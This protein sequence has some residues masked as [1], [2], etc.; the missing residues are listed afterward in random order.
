MCL[1]HRY[2]R[3]ET[4][5]PVLSKSVVFGALFGIQMW[6]DDVKMTQNRTTF[7]H[8]L[9]SR[10]LKFCRYLRHFSEV[11]C[12]Q[13]F[14]FLLHVLGRSCFGPFERLLGHFGASQDCPNRHLTFINGALGSVK[15]MVLKNTCILQ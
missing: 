12:F 9:A 2:L 13:S 5:I 1:G 11:W 6:P 3:Y 10:T 15:R 8:T 7:E 4:R 14:S